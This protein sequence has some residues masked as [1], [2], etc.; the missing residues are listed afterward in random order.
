MSLTR[1]QTLSLIGGGTIL[2]ATAAGA[3]FVSTRTPTRA[4]QPW[5]QAGRY[6]DVRL[7]ALSFA[8]LAPNPHNLQPWQVALEGD[9]A[10]LL[11]RDPTR[12]LPE[13]DPFDRQITIG[14]GCFLEQMVLAAG[15]AG[16]AVDLTLFPQGPDGP[17]AHA[18]FGAGGAADPLAAHI[19][20][21]RSCKEPFEDKAVPAPLARQL[22]AYADIYTD[23]P[24]VQA[25]TSL[26]WDAWLVEA[27]TPRTMQESVDLMRFGKAEINA[28]PDGIDLGGPFLESLMLLG[29]VS[30]KVQADPAS[31]GFKQGIELYRA[32]LQATP[33]YAVLTSPTNTRTDQI[34]AGRRWLRL[35]LAVTGLGLSLHPVSQALQEYPEMADHYATAHN[36]LAP[37]GHTVQ[38][39]GRLG[40]GPS[41][42]PSPRWPLETKL[43]DRT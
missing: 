7:N 9:D 1:R 18:V 37:Q 24:S 15:A 39:L 4:L 28:N 42:A 33:A 41:R 23:A 3:G 30:R 5:Q 10:L 38:M 34:D 25:L 16:Y 19:L 20:A 17:V 6:D 35:N 22:E 27:M 32:M 29:V 31:T 8:L 14:L 26:T 40:Y 21:R 11:H 36:L 12:H 2:A 13:T 43:I